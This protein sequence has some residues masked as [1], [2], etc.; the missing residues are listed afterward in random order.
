MVNFLLVDGA[1][2][3]REKGRGA[4]RREGELLDCLHVIKFIYV[5]CNSCVI[6]RTAGLFG[7]KFG[8]KL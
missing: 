2:R 4:G 3:V 5:G 8:M 1:Q 6:Y 7:M